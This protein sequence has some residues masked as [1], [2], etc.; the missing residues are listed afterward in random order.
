MT[1]HGAIMA[2]HIAAGLIALAV[3]NLG[4]R[5]AQ[6]RRDARASRDLVLRLDA[7]ARSHRCDPR[8]VPRPPGPGSPIGGLIVCYFV[9]TS[10]IAARRRDG[11]TGRFEIARLRGRARPVRPDVLGRLQRQHD[12]RGPGPGIRHRRRLPARR[13]ARS[14]RDPAREA[15]ARAAD[16]AASVA[17]V[18]SPS[19]SP[20]A[21][22]SSASRMSCRRR[23]AARR[24]CSSWPSRRSRVMAFWLVR[25][26]FSKMISGLKLRAPAPPAPRSAL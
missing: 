20:P 10:W 2:I 21:P 22:S 3:R 6:G 7:R 26:R 19:S 12:A 13:A 4:R 25:V 16:R 14:Q 24:S 9:A 17:D 23:C 8:A 5:R 1:L 15:H 11:T 18:R